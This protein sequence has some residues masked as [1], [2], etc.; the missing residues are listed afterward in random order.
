MEY[1]IN[2]YQKL[3]GKPPAR[4]ELYPNNNE[5]ANLLAMHISSGH[6]QIYIWDLLDVNSLTFPLPAKI[7]KLIRE[8]VTGVA[9]TSVILGV[10]AY[11]SLLGEDNRQQFHLAMRQMLDEQKLHIVFLM[12]RS[13]FRAHS[14]S[15]PKY[16]NSLQ[17]IR[18]SGTISEQPA[19]QVF[20]YPERFVPQDTNFRGYKDLMKH[21]GQDVD[22]SKYIV[23]LPSVAI[24]QAG[25]SSDVHFVSEAH[26]IA[27]SYYAVE[28]PFDDKIINDLLIECRTLNLSPEETAE[29]LFGS[30][31]ISTSRAIKRLLQL[32]TDKFWVTFIW[33][34]KQ[35]I[36]NTSYLSKVLCGLIEPDNLLRKY[37]VDTAVNCVVND[38]SKIS[39]YAAERAEVLSSLGMPFEP[40]I[41]DFIS[42]V[43]TY[44]SALPFLN[45][46]T[47]TERC[48]LI[49]RAGEL[50]LV[51]GL[52]A[53]FNTLCPVLGDYLSSVSCGNST[54]D[55][56]F[57][58]YR[59]NSIKN[60]V[61][62]SFVDLAFKNSA[63]IASIKMRDSILTDLSAQNDTAL[64]IVDG[65]GVEYL[66][67][68]ISAAAR[69]GLT[70]SYYEVAAA[71][72]PSST[73][74]NKIQWN[75]E[76]V[77]DGVNSVDNIAHYGASKHENCTSE[78]NILATLDEL[79]IE[80]LKR[81]VAGLSAH[82]QVIVTSDHGTSK[83]A[84]TAHNSGLS[85]TLPWS[86]DPDD[87]RFSAAQENSSVPD[88][89]ES[90]Y[91]PS[92]GKTYWVVRG[93]NRLPKKGP[94]LYALHGGATLEERLVP[95]IVFTALKVGTSILAQKK[96]ADA[97][98]VEKDDF[99]I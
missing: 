81:V 8:K 70:V 92:S 55:T 86:G 23:V 6:K 74:Y 15:N 26:E 50:D 66:P 91:S 96:K 76:L 48:E 93:Y 78:R 41:V 36:D 59:R 44:K 88:G 98:L 72:L 60:E 21:F 37:V 28:L 19:P 67:F 10:D 14:F 49:R 61:S 58:A 56:Y 47:V 51:A 52:P 20:V 18:I 57:K 43:K 38:D 95:I 3:E 63:P 87:W 34:L 16:E 2:S 46:G 5:A 9:I 22:S 83:L 39:Q 99:D 73:T 64:L 42:K 71:R 79:G 13:L 40:L 24:K 25:Q 1:T 82:A 17:L 65:M 89:M 29:S 54:L 80:V 32:K 53:E 68:L 85:E 90:C 69:Q 30:T 27:S 4:I 45:C 12:S 7:I 77:L 75:P 33:L 94:K 11:L 35:R 84:V 31:H 97:Q 62:S